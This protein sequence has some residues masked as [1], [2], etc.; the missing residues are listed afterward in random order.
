MTI[1][2]IETEHNGVLFRSRLEARWAVFFD[3]LGIKYCYEREGYSLPSGNYLPDF[4][5]PNQRR[6]KHDQSGL[7]VEVKGSVEPKH[8]T[9]LRELSMHTRAGCTLVKD[10]PYPQPAILRGATDYRRCEYQDGQFAI[11]EQWTIYGCYKLHGE[12]CEGSDDKFPCDCAWSESEDGP[13]AWCQ[14]PFCG[15][16]GFEF[17]G[18]SA[19]IGCNCKQHNGDKT[20]NA[21][22]VDLLSA[23][24]AAR[25][26]R[27]EHWR[28]A[29]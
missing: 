15:I 26:A 14:C 16:V 11:D 8:L 4:Y 3:A 6:F 27:F 18:R 7:F 2:A 25:R 22:A 9:L 28:S 13:Y 19:R 24:S 21:G 5:L 1:A 10:I 20:Y 23:Y 12:H 17:D 29:A